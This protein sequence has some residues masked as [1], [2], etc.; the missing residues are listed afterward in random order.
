MNKL[1]LIA[2]ACASLLPACS[3]MPTY[4]R[5]NAPVA[6]QWPGMATAADHKKE[7]NQTN[8]D[9][10]WKDFFSDPT[11]RELIDTALANN[12]DL[13]VSV[14]NIEQA[15]AQL[16]IRRA[17]QYPTVNATVTGSR[18]PNNDG[19][20][21]SAYAGGLTVTAYELDFFG[22]VASL[23]E[24]A[25]AQYLATQEGS[26][27]AHISL[28]ATVAQSWLSLLADEELLSASRQTLASREASLNLVSLR[29]QHGAASEL[30]LRLAQTLR[31]SARATLAQQQRQRALDENAL[32]LLLGQALPASAQAKLANAQLGALRFADLPAGLPSELLARRPD[33]RQA[34]QQ[35]IASHANI[36]AARAAFFPRISLT[37]GAGSASGELAGLFKDGSWGWTLA[38]QLVLP[39]FDAG[40][41]QANLD[42]AKVTRDIAVAQYE[43]AIQSA[44]REVSDALAGRDTLAQQLQ[45]S[46]ALLDA[47][48][49]RSNLTKLRFDKGAASQLDWLDA[50]RSLFAAQQALIQTRLASL[51]NQVVLYKV[52]GGGFL[53]EPSPD[54]VAQTTGAAR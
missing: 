3:L 38:P 19:S 7:S 1:S 44:F 27:T 4:E 37:V 24:Q 13:R 49:A 51:Q 32:T 30:D 39:I 11:V 54:T 47:E 28:M 36:G 41:N 15:R 9:L 33:I 12:R 6:A 43:K 42:S 53:A 17:D 20:I 10:G 31:E 50:Q 16:G 8:K 5:P 14:L 29:L 26:K 40:R 18:T 23:K 21:K 46:Q 52:L 48:T 35:L 25:L 34:E 2:L 45:A 22:R